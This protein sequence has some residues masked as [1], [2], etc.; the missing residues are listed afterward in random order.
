[1]TPSVIL[2]F[3]E[4]QTGIPRPDGLF[5]YGRDDLTERN[6]TFEITQYLPG[7]LLIGDDSGS[8]GVLVH[9]E[10]SA[11]PVYLCDLGVLAEE[12]LV[13]L[14]PTLHHWIELSCPLPD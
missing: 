13:P 10:L 6:E 4:Q 11:Y 1:M 9:Y 5:L 14:A 12:D 2:T 8:R 3:V 7:Y